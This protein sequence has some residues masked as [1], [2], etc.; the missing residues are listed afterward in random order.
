MKVAPLRQE[1]QWKQLT[2]DKR[3]NG[4]SSFTTREA[5]RK[6]AN[7]LQLGEL[8][9]S[10]PQPRPQP[11]IRAAKKIAV[12][13]TTQPDTFHRSSLSRSAIWKGFA[14]RSCRYDNPALPHWAAFA[15]AC[16]KPLRTW[17]KRKLSLAWRHASICHGLILGVALKCSAG[18]SVHPQS[19][20][21]DQPCRTNSLGTRSRGFPCSRFR[22]ALTVRLLTFSGVRWL[23]MP[24]P[25]LAAV[26]RFV[27]SGVRVTIPGGG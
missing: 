7:S 24:T 14:G 19:A 22:P 26:V 2:C 9:P 16:T 5:A 4:S 8:H 3:A 10:R 27:L 11:Q 17:T 25:C 6:L 21:G 15:R 20:L 18:S 12:P 1:A 23:R 13:K